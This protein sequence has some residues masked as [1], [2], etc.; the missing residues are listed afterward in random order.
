MSLMS[1]EEDCARRP[2]RVGGRARRQVS[3]SAAEAKAKAEALLVSDRSYLRTEVIS[4]LHQYIALT[5]DRLEQLARLKIDFSPERDSFA[6]TLSRYRLDGLIE[7]VPVSLVKR[8]AKFG[9]TP[10][11]PDR[12]LQAW[13]LGP[14]GKALARARWVDAEELP[15]VPAT[16]EHRLHDLICTE[17]MFKLWESNRNM[18]SSQQFHVYGPRQCAIW[19]QAKG[20]YLCRPDGFLLKKSA[21]GHVGKAYAIEYHNTPVGDRARKKVQLYENLAKHPELWQAHWP[22]MPNVLIIARHVATLNQYRAV[23]N[24]YPAVAGAYLGMSLDEVLASKLETM[25]LREPKA[26]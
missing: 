2:A 25:I 1:S 3:F 10:L 22:M 6:T 12:P 19:D 17:A 20:A 13:T 7:A 23:L 14:V 11:R 18:K 26:N 15:E 21:A 8:A 16:D 4:L 9:I 5:Q 24:E